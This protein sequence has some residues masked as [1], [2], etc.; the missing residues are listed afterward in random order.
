MPDLRQEVVA[1]GE[2]FAVLLLELLDRA[3]VFGARLFEI[4]DGGLVLINGAP[5]LLV[6]GLEGVE[7]ST[8][9]FAAG[10]FLFKELS[11]FA[12]FKGL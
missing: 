9:G 2:L 1:L 3:G 8:V 6:C 5:G 7:G 4:G 10:L 12:S 11:E